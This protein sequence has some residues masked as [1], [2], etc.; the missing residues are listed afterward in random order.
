MRFF[1]RKRKLWMVIMAVAS[2]SLV[3]S[4]ILPYILQ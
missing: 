3:L 4:S 2:L 1:R